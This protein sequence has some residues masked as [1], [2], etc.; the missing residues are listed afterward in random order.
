MSVAVT[1]ALSRH[2]RK[3]FSCT[4]HFLA[5][6]PEEDPNPDSAEWVT[7]NGTRSLYSHKHNG[8]GVEAVQDARFPGLGVSLMHTASRPPLRRFLAIDRAVRA[9][10]FPTAEVMARELEVNR[11]TI[12]RDIDFMRHSLGAPLRVCR[13]H[14]GYHYTEPDWRLPFFSLTEGELVSLFVAERVLQQYRG[15]AFEADLSRAFR[16]ITE[17]LGDEV[18]LNLADLDEAHSF[19]LSAP[20]PQ[21]VETFRRLVAAVRARHSVRITYWTASRDEVNQRTVDPLHLAN[22]DGDW[23]LLAYCHRR[24][25]VLTFAPSRIRELRVTDETFAPPAGFSP[26]AHL[27]GSFRVIREEHGH[28][29]CV[30]LRFSAFAARYVGERTWHPSQTSVRLPDGRLE[31]E[32]HVASLIEV[33]KWAL[34]FGSDC[35][36]LAPAELRSQIQEEARKMLEA[37]AAGSD[38]NL[39]GAAPQAVR[40]PTHRK[41]PAPSKARRT[42]RPE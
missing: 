20:S 24:K 19:R 34:S 4:P 5:A 31:I 38:P 30:R 9:G 25:R 6:P 21:D 37:H 39:G 1:V 42:T 32:M 3:N 29:H 8:D 22:I 16:K 27:A 10:R 23:F 12:F 26:Q 11:R 14:R 41:L 28:V 7:V 17:Q 35:E 13:T 36:V 2:R 33:K 15:T 40:P 18:T